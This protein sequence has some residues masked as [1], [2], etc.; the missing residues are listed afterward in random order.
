M[1]R[2]ATNAGA[3]NVAQITRDI[4]GYHTTPTEAAEIARDAGARYLLFDHIV[5]P[6][7]IAPLREVFVEG[8]AEIYHGPATIGRDG[9]FIT[10]PA[11]SDRIEHD[12]LL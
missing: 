2:A 3:A 9:T 7:P 6:L 11:G 10:M 5:P 1:T 8:V 12:E 4:V